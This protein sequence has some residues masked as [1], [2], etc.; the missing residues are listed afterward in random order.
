MNL[1]TEQARE[2][3]ESNR[4]SNERELIYYLSEIS[5]MLNVIANELETLSGKPLPRI[6]CVTE[7]IAECDRQKAE[8][9]ASIKRRARA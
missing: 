5:L 8:R 4:E 3:N 6:M 7:L 2:R 1:T 9:A